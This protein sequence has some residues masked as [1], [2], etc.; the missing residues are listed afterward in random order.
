MQ[1]A[2]AK[3]PSYMLLTQFGFYQN[4]KPNMQAISMIEVS[5]V[6]FKLNFT[7]IW[8]DISYGSFE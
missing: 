7:D 2:K 6:N 8:P 4:M 3:Y 1:N 5:N